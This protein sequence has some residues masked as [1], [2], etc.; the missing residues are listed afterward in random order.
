MC[1]F[2][3]LV[4][5][6]VVIGQLIIVVARGTVRVIYWME[7]HD[8]FMTFL[9]TFAIAVLTWRLWARSNQQYEK[10]GFSMDTRDLLALGVALVLTLIGVVVIV[11]LA[12]GQTPIELLR[13]LTLKRE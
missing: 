10:S 8:G 7:A 11:A 9:A 2:E 5:S 12:R 6:L 13:Q 4:L 1:V 3:M